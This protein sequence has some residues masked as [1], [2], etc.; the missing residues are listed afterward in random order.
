MVSGQS[1]LS[2]RHTKCMCTG[3]NV[4]QST[5]MCLGDKGTKLILGV[6]SAAVAKISATR[7]IKPIKGNLKI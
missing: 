6:V 3:I 7:E 4:S 2:K 5:I 1:G